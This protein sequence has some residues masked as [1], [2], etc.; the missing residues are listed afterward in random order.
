VQWLRGSVRLMRIGCT[1]GVLGSI[2]ISLFIILRPQPR[3]AD[4][5]VL[6]E[7]NIRIASNKVLH[8]RFVCS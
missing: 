3:V 5:S 8:N 6:Q 1:V 2:C 4:S 7:S